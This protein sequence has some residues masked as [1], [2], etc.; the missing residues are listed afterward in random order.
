MATG[1]HYIR[2]IKAETRGWTQT[3]KLKTGT[4]KDQVFLQSRAVVAHAF[5]LSA[6]EQRQA[7]LFESKASPVYRVSFWT[8]RA[9]E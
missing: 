7:Q 6:W 3:K 4:G 1:Q 2:D 9:T 5:D 8:A